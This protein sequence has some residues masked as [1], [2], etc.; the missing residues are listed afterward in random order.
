MNKL[1]WPDKTN[2]DKIIQKLYNETYTVMLISAAIDVMVALI[3][4]YVISRYLGE[5]SVAAVGVLYP[6]MT[7]MAAIGM[8][9]SN[10]IQV[11]CSKHMG[12][13]D[14]KKADAAFS[15]SVMSVFVFSIVISV[16]TACFSEQVAAL[17]GARMDLKL[18]NESK[19]YLL[20]I[21]M[22]AP[23]YLLIVY[24]MPLLQLDGDKKRDVIAVNVMAVADIIG[25]LVLGVFLKMGIFGIGVATSVSEYIAL[26]VLLT[27]FCSKNNNMHFSIKI[28]KLEYIKDVL[29]AGAVC[30][31]KKFMSVITSLFI[32]NIVVRYGT[33]ATMAGFALFKSTKNVFAMFAEAGASTV[34]LLSGMLYAEKDRRGL[35]QLF[36]SNLKTASGLSAVM[37]II[38][39]IFSRIFYSFFASGDT[40]DSV[41]LFT[42]V[43]G[44][45]LVFTS[46]KFFY[47]GY[48]QG[49][50]KK[51]MCWML[52]FWG[53]CGFV[54]LT[55]IPFVLLFGQ[56][57][58]SLGYNSIDIFT[59]PL[60]VVVISK[61]LH[62]IPKSID[63]LLLLNDDFRE[64]SKRTYDITIEDGSYWRKNI[65]EIQDFCKVNGADDRKSF[66]VALA[67]E[68]MVANIMQYG[69]KNKKM[70]ID[71]RILVQEDK[72]I[73]LRIRDN[74]PAF[75]PKDK[76][77]LIKHGDKTENIGIRIV[78][79]IASR[80]EYIYS[81]GLNSLI[82][83]V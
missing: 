76:Y 35:R 17:C 82:I 47:S 40:L 33:L 58:I 27:H 12:S 83:E 71:V 31:V 69:I 39:V 8:V 16:I 68:E 1:F 56:P 62:H 57:G 5:L 53:E 7:V 50:Q 14:K 23:A 19:K 42:R 77:E 48:F 9:F 38:L 74:C 46:L 28:I 24:L 65:E 4:T 22:G 2:C 78:N 51:G 13:G 44:T 32:N 36:I 29:S 72:S 59:V 25:N 70:C 73:M 75:N 21:I 34:L 10:G 45:V 15:G 63:D 3:D 26:A 41:V 55:T 61:M 30:S 79:G 64:S 67:A 37:G 49:I 18:L 81:A 6:F 54:L 43:L 80:W 66:F 20:G 60:L 11:I 52:A